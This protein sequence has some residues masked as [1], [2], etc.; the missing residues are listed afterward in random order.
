[1]I[2]T[3][4]RF[5]VRCVDLV[6][7]EGQAAQRGVYRLA[8]AILAAALG[9]ILIVAGLI[10]LAMGVIFA[11]EPAL[12]WAGSF[13]LTSV[14]FVAIGSVTILIVHRRMSS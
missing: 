13:L 12:G 5:V 4:S 6:E 10:V 11:L 14:F 7:A 1:V 3:L 8:G 9:G 2:N